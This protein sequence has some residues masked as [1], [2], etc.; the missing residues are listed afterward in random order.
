MTGSNP[1]VLV[2]TGLFKLVKFI[3]LPLA[4]V[5]II[6]GVLVKNR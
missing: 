5:I 3:V 6:L 2:F 1:L 4:W